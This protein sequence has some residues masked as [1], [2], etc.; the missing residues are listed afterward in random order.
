MDLLVHGGTMNKTTAIL[1]TLLSAYILY[2]T[3]TI[4]HTLGKRA[5]YKEILSIIGTP[6]DVLEEIL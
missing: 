3:F 4:G 5:A 6:E 1:I 2:G